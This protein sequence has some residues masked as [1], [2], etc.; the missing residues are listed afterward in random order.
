[1]LEI[2]KEVLLLFPGPEIDSDESWSPASG[3]SSIKSRRKSTTTTLAATSEKKGLRR[4]RQPV[5]D[6]KERKKI[7]N[8]E[9][10]R[11][12]RYKNKTINTTQ[13]YFRIFFI[14]IERSFRYLELLI[15]PKLIFCRNFPESQQLEYLSGFCNAKSFIPFPIIDDVKYF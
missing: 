15:F 3:V 10:A 9:A 7:Q 12:Y 14:T 5:I 4:T 13:P 2:K 6:K 8:V 11:R 1:M